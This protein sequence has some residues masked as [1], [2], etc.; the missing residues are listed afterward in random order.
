MA[1][2]WV[3][4]SLDPYVLLPW[5]LYLHQFQAHTSY[6]IFCS[7]LSAKWRLSYLFLVVSLNSLND[8]SILPMPLQPVG[9]IGTVGR[10]VY[11][12]INFNIR[13]HSLSQ[14][15]LPGPYVQVP[16]TRR[17]TDVLLAELS[18][19]ATIISFWDKTTNPAVYI[20]VCLVVAIGI[21]VLG[22]GEHLSMILTLFPL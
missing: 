21:N 14:F 2:S 4:S 6:I 17:R 7:F 9:I 22:V 11:F 3:T 13:T 19:A 12:D 5:S 18:A 20:T 16:V 15:T 10:Y 8:S 1:F